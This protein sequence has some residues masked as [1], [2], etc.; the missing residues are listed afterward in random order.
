[1]TV[2]IHGA[3]TVENSST[4]IDASTDAGHGILNDAAS[5][6]VLP[7][8][9]VPIIR[10]NINTT[11]SNRTY[12]VDGGEAIVLPAGSPGQEVAG[13]VAVGSITQIVR[14]GAGGANPFVDV[15]IE[16]T[17]DAACVG[18]D[19][20][21]VIQWPHLDLGSFGVEKQFIGFDLVATAPE[22]VSVSI[23]YDQRDL[24]RRTAD[25]LMDADTLPGKLVPIAVTAPSFDMRLT[26]E[27]GQRWEW[28][29]SCLYINDR[30]PGA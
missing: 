12:T 4:P 2:T 14:T 23:G 6:Y 10:H 15:G 5:V 16:F 24:T 26:F 30:R 29:A 7:A 18:E 8:A 25:Y 3:I 9:A 19:I 21:G 27:P 11:T 22:G 1:L 17:V 28:N 20:V 13:V